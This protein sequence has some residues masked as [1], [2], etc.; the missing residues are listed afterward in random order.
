M[1]QI[2]DELSPN[3]AGPDRIEWDYIYE[4]ASSHGGKDKISK[5][6]GG[7]IHVLEQPIRPQLLASIL[8]FSDE[9][10]ENSS[11]ADRYN[12]LFKNI[13]DTSKLYHE[14]ALALDSV[15]IKANEREVY[16]YFVVDEDKLC[17]KYKKVINGKTTETY[18]I[19]EIY[20]RTLKTHYERLY[21]MRF[22]RP[23]INID[24]IRVNIKI[25]LRNRK[26][27]S[28]NFD[29]VETGLNSLKIDDMYNL[30]PELLKWTGHILCEKSTEQSL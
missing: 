9:L 13:P 20:L 8:K 28:T 2:N 3:F 21:C 29:L 14:Y 5:L 10:A 6:D 24:R 4:I 12:L 23:L 22:M 7:E 16:M 30:C 11:R 1:K 25:R 27:F 18:L 26:W 15:I 17:N 19:D